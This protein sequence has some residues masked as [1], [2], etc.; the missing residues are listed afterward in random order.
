MAGA[1]GS[2]KAIESV[3]ERYYAPELKLN[4]YAHRSDP[5]NGESVYRMLY[6]KRSEP[7]AQLFRAPVGYAITEG[8]K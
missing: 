4:V 6:V 2:S 3:Y 8:K 5:R 1:I 7:D